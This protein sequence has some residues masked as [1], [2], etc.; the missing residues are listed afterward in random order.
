MSVDPSSSLDD[1]LKRV[2]K[3]ELYAEPLLN[4][5]TSPWLA[6][7]KGILKKVKAAIGQ[8]AY[9][10]HEGAGLTPR[11]AFIVEALEQINDYVVVK[12]AKWARAKIKISRE[13][14]QKIEKAVLHRILFGRDLQRWGIKAERSTFYS[15]L[16]YEPRAG[17]IYS[18][19]VAKAR[20]PNAYS[21]LHNFKSYLVKGANYKQFGKGFPFF[22]IYRVSKYTF[23]PFKVMW[24]EV[25]TMVDA[26]VVSKLNDPLLGE[27]LAIPDYTC[28]YIPLQHEEEAHYLCA[29]LN[30]TIS[31]C[32]TSYIHL[33]P[34]PHV[35]DFIKVPRFDKTTKLHVELAKLSKEAHDFTIKGNAAELRKVEAT[36]DMFVAQLYGLTNEELAHVQ[37]SLAILKGEEV[38]EEVIEEE[39]K[40][41]KV[42]FLNAVMSPHGVGSFEVAVMNPLKGEVTIELQLPDHSVKLK[43]EKQEDTLKVKVPPL[44]VG[45]YKVPYKVIVHGKVTK[46]KFTLYVKKKKRFRDKEALSSKLDELLGD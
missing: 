29:I 34:D 37:K 23:A 2:R 22:F 35:M 41:V 18:E 38:E 20:Y 27:I 4:R 42:D 10:A 21:F 16:L 36:I 33:H 12:N 7:E 24:K 44:Q 5:K 9:K 13:I 40:E 11:G 1:V 6:L 26:V 25:G 19:S 14:T 28:V 8:A 45:E 43:T 32:I 31:R 39:P 46:G 15:I 17:T 3:I 30:S